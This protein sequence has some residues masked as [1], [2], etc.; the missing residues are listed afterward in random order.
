[1]WLFGGKPPASGPLTLDLEG[2][3]LGPVESVVLAR[4]LSTTE[5]VRELKLRRRT[6]A[7]NPHGGKRRRATPTDLAALCADL[8]S[9]R[10]AARAS[11]ACSGST[12]KGRTE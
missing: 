5:S 7:R 1:M 4:L 9:R 2:A 12:H 3:G 6:H 11:G 10:N 8:R